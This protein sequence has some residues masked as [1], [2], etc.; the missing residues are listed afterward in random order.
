MPG[1][2]SLLVVFVFTFAIAAPARA[3]SP[4][5]I[6]VSCPEGTHHRSEGGYPFFRPT[7]DLFAGLYRDIQPITPCPE[8]RKSSKPS[9]PKRRPS[10]SRAAKA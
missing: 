2:W 8:T 7:I 6:P 10:S 3:W 9:S 5:M 1:K 4:V